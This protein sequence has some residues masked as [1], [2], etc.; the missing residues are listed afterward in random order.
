MSD[1]LWRDGFSDIAAGWMMIDD[2]DDLTERIERLAEWTKA[3]G[4]LRPVEAATVKFMIESQIA[5]GIRRGHFGGGP[6]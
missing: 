3:N 1:D 2:F 6:R 5:R 4:P